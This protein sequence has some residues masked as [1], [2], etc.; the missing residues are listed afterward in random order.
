MAGLSDLDFKSGLAFQDQARSRFVVSV[1]PISSSKSFTLVASF[2]RSTIRLDVDSMSL[3]LQACVG[4]TMVDFGLRWLKAWS[5]GFLISCKQIGI[6]IH[7]LPCIKGNAFIVQF[8]LWRN[9]GPNWQHELI[10]WE[11]L[12]DAEWHQVVRK[13][14]SFCGDGQVAAPCQSSR[15]DQEGVNLQIA[16]VP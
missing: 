14:K 13:K 9:G 16:H 5:F 4:G 8:T 6:I 10:K 12:Q 11:A 7:H 2:S 1:S 3:I 15:G